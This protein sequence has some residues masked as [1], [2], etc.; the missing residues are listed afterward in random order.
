MDRI[1]LVA[2]YEWSRIYH[3]Y[4]LADGEHLVRS[5]DFTPQLA[6]EITSFQPEVVVADLSGEHAPT[7]LLW[8]TVKE[9]PEPRPAV[10]FSMGA[11]NWGELHVY[12]GG[13]YAMKSLLSGALPKIV[14]NVLCS[15]GLKNPPVVPGSQR[16]M[17]G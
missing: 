1:L 15:Q 10:V 2:S 7:N 16:P 17:K 4:Q 3:A 12:Q 6:E 14:E 8:Q 9:L 5:T 13:D 11:N